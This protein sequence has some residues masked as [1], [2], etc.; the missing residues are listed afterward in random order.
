M[1]G[2]LFL[3]LLLC[4]FCFTSFASADATLFVS[5]VTG[6]YVH[7]D[8]MRVA[9]MLSSAD[10]PV[11]AAEGTLEYDPKEFRLERIDTNGSAIVSW[12]KMPAVDDSPGIISFAGAFASGHAA[13]R[14]KLFDIVLVPLRS[15]EL[16]LRWGSGA[17]IHAAD[18]TGGNIVSA[19]SGGV[20]LIEPKN[21]TPEFSEESM[22]APTET[23]ATS[24]A[25]GEVLGAE[26]VAA[27]SP[28]EVSMETNEI[29]AANATSAT[30]SLPLSDN[31]A[32]AAHN[33]STAET[34]E[35]MSGNEKN[36]YSIGML[37]RHPFMLVGGIILV[38]LFAMT[39]YFWR[40]SV[41]KHVTGTTDHTHSA[42]SRDPFR[43]SLK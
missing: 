6:N 9:V 8:E 16:R 14:E 17:A 43:V 1:R 4:F 19:L 11:N 39:V 10:M 42:T 21:S 31:Q 25:T 40:V 13:A 41:R 34:Q 38:M 28:S 22:G 12:T 33:L 23:L 18:G 27:P 15:G 30:V 32:A 37:K 29:N 26:D 5:P 36:I 20:Y 3:L 35:K 24:D 2:K 7:G